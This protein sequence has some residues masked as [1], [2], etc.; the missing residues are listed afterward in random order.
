MA[1]SAPCL[2]ASSPPLCPC[3]QHRKLTLP[4]PPVPNPIQG[5][6][7]AG[8]QTWAREEG[9]SLLPCRERGPAFPQHPQEG[10]KTHTGACGKGLDLAV[11]G[12]CGIQA[13][14]SA[15]SVRVSVRSFKG[16][17]VVASCILG[18]DTVPLPELAPGRRS[19]HRQHE[20]ITPVGI[21]CPL[22]TDW[23]RAPPPTLSVGSQTH[24]IPLQFVARQCQALPSGP[25]E[26]RGRRAAFAISLSKAARL[27]GGVGIT[28]QASFPGQ[29]PHCVP[30]R[31]H[32]PTAQQS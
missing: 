29:R 20:V 14:G 21:S 1:R 5:A 3:P 15:D 6:G 31:F 2:W 25:P 23:R 9:A 11:A 17:W 24:L 19:Q 13:L 16:P 30:S 18:Q 12:L 10:P 22:N 4:P 32:S 28:T 8:V 27:G 7:R 26:H